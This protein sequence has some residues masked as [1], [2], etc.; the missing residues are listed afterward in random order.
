MTKTMAQFPSALIRALCFLSLLT[1]ACAFTSLVQA[2]D[3]AIDPKVSAV[4]FSGTH[5]GKPFE[6]NFG[7]W[8]ATIAFDPENLSESKINATLKT[9]SARTGNAMYDGTLPQ[10]DWFHTKEFPEITFT[11]TAITH[12]QDNQYSATGDLTIRGKTLPVTF[13]FTLS[14]LSVAPVTAS[15]AFTIDRLAYDIGKK[16]DPKS[17]WVGGEIAVKLDVTA[18]RK[19]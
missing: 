2:A 3:Y 5:A 9:A 18:T 15:A 10:S 6:G 13:D 17:E 7:E 16:S 19:P 4:H 12:K 14:D 11:S 8:T 1:F